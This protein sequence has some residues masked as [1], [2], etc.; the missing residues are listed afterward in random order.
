MPDLPNFK[1]AYNT[2]LELLKVSKYRPVTPV[3]KL[4]WDEHARA[5]DQGIRHVYP[6]KKALELAE[7][8]VQK[9]LDEIYKEHDVRPPVNWNKVW[10]VLSILFIIFITVILYLFSK[11]RKNAT[12]LQAKE[13][14][15]GMA[16]CSTMDY[17]I[18]GFSS[19][20]HDLFVHFNI[21]QI[22]CS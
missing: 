18:C 4:L 9:E 7:E 5:M 21:L 20:P 22:Q 3:G 2:F 17:W 16:F 15:T 14:Y 10:C 19:W 1:Q 8:R 12:A 13:A 11:W 6:P